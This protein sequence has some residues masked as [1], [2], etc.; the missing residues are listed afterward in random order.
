MKP[1]KSFFTLIE[2]L[3]VIAIIAIL[4]GML[5]PALNNARG[6]AKAIGCI[7]NLKQVGNC[8]LIYANDYDDWVLPGAFPTTVP[9]PDGTAGK[10]WYSFIMVPASTNHAILRCPSANADIQYKVS[11]TPYYTGADTLD[12]ISYIAI[13][14]AGGYGNNLATYPY[15]KINRLKNLSKR[16]Y[17]VDTAR[18]DFVITS[19][20]LVNN[21][22]YRSNAFRHANQINMQMMDGHVGTYRKRLLWGNELV[23]GL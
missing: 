3:V 10:Y 19:G 20:E 11:K 12:R 9:M 13:V 1:A 5:L 16:G 17:I 18:A 15:R 7:N 21:A 8:I 22:T 14:D 4:A 6:K 23:W 2:L